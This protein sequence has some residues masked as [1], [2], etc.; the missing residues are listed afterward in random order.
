MIDLSDGLAGDAAHLAAAADAAILLSPGALPVHPAAR[1]AAG[2]EEEALRWAV[3][4]GEEYELCF[5]AAPGRVGGAAE[6]FAERF[7]AFVAKPRRKAVRAAF[8]GAA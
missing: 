2:S 5:A 8:G 4:G 3:G 7:G 1:A 6:E